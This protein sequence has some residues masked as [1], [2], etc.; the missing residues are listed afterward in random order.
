M[1]GVLRAAN[2]KRSMETK[3]AGESLFNDGVAYVV[4]LI[5]VGLAFPS[6]HD[7]HVLG[8]IDILKL[9]VQ[10]AIAMDA[11][12]AFDTPSGPHLAPIWPSMFLSPTRAIITRLMMGY[13]KTSR[14]SRAG[15]SIHPCGG[16]R[17]DPP[18]YRPVSTDHPETAHIGRPV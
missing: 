12:G 18:V 1:L 9:F 4:F 10:E 15:F 7:A 2:L 13:R 14:E 5:L 11:I 6:G 17:A 16:S 3:I 8:F